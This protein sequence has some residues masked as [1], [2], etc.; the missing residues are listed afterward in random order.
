VNERERQDMMIYPYEVHHPE[1]EHMPPKFR[2]WASALAAQKM[3]NTQVPGH[4]A[5]KR[6]PIPGVRAIRRESVR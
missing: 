4:K 3:W 1:S 2:T 5:R 6:K